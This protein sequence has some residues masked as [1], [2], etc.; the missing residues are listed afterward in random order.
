MVALD[1][2]KIYKYP[3]GS[4]LLNDILVEH[5]RLLWELEDLAKELQ[6][7][8][9]SSL[10]NKL[11]LVKAQILLFER[12]MIGEKID[13]LVVLVNYYAEKLS[14]PRVEISK[15]NAQ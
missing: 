3:Y 9:N 14:E 6:S 11:N 12:L 10:T 7:D 8:A 1:L 5:E 4:D 2:K 13:S 15:V